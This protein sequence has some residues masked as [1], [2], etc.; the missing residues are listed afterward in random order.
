MLIWLRLLM[1]FSRGCAKNEDRT[2][3]SHINKL[4]E[5]KNTI[6]KVYSRKH[7]EVKSMQKS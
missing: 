6:F 2:N 4:H 1:T 7:Q 3:R 5:T